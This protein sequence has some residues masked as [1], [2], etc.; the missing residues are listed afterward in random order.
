MV[1]ILALKT[2]M[3]CNFRCVTKFAGYFIAISA[4]K[5]AAETIATS[6]AAHIAVCNCM[7]L[8]GTISLADRELVVETIYYYCSRTVFGCLKAWGLFVFVL[9]LNTYRFFIISSLN[10]TSNYANEAA[11]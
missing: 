10:R 8:V 2:K 3:I 6:I 7:V 1:L 5:Q 11:I 9:D 4:S